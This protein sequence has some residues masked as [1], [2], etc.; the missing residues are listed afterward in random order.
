[1]ARRYGERETVSSGSRLYFVGASAVGV[2]KPGVENGDLRVD[3]RGF[4]QAFIVRCDASG[5]ENTA[6]VLE[7]CAELRIKM[8]SDAMSASRSL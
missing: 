1:M 7:M 3:D 5:R 4:L 6:N 2:V 8:L